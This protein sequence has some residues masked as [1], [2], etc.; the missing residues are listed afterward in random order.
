M[1]PLPPMRQASHRARPRQG[2]LRRRGAVA[3]LRAALL[4]AACARRATRLVVGT[5]KPIAVEPR[6]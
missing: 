5:E 6:N 2:R 1:Q 4:D 3:A